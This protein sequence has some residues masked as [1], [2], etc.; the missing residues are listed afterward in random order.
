MPAES[1]KVTPV[2]LTKTRCPLNASVRVSATDGSTS[3]LTVTKRVPSRSRTLSSN[4]APSIGGLVLLTCYPSW[5]LRTG[6]ASE[7]LAVRVELSQLGPAI[8]RWEKS[9]IVR[10]EVDVLLDVFGVLLFSG[11]G[12][13]HQRQHHS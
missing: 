2:M 11:S 8:C 13:R 5:V 6:T 10:I 4:G 12:G 7:P 1:I 3:P 9:V